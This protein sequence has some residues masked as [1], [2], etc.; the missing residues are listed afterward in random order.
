M[1]FKKCKFSVQVQ[2]EPDMIMIGYIQ[3]MS[4]MDFMCLSNSSSN[5]EFMVILQVCSAVSTYHTLQNRI[6]TE[7]MFIIKIDFACGSFGL[8]VERFFFSFYQIILN[9][10]RFLKMISLTLFRFLSVHLPYVLMQLC[11]IFFYGCI[12]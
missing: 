9:P 11:Y 6:L 10:F 5:V 2:E 3:N 7:I 4:I 12:F 1:Q 8:S